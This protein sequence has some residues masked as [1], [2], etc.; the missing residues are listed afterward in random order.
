MNALTWLLGT[1]RRAR[2][3]EWWLVNIGVTTVVVVGSWLTMV[4]I[5]GGAPSDPNALAARMPWILFSQFVWMALAFGTLAAVSIRRAHDR[6]STGWAVLA[7]MGLSMLIGLVP[8]LLPPQMWNAI[9]GPFLAFS[10]IFWVC[11]L[12]FF[13]TLGFLE[14]DDDDNRYGPSP[15][16]ER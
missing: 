15:K 5:S 13:V 7:Y 14:G 6:D 8:T 1:D 2:R 16:S 4:V 9:W 10:A 12:Y 11:G 3:R